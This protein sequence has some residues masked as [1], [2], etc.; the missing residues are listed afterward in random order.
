[1]IGQLVKDLGFIGDTKQCE[2]ILNGI[3]SILHE[4]DSYTAEYI[5]ALAKL[6]SIINAPKLVISI[7]TFI[8]GWKKIKERTSAGLSGI[9][10]GFLKAYAMSEELVDFEATVCYIP[11]AT[12]YSPEEWRSGINTMIEKKGKGNLVT[13]LRTI[14]LI[15]ADFNYVNKVIARE[16]L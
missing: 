3:Y 6:S 14:N 10:F 8:E 5:K 13:D 12:G 16:I 2:A 9:Y 4:V 1:M 7:V 11:Y 15:E